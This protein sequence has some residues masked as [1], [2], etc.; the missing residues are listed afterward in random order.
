VKKD[1]NEAL[2]DILYTELIQSPKPTYVDEAAAEIAL[3]S[4][5]SKWIDILCRN[6]TALYLLRRFARCASRTRDQAERDEILGNFLLAFLQLVDR[7]E[8]TTAR[9]QVERVRL[10]YQHLLTA[11]KNL[12]LEP[13]YPLNHWN[14]LPEDLRPLSFALRTQ[15]FGLLKIHPDRTLKL[16]FHANEMHD[17]LWELACQDTL[18]HRLHFLLAA[19][20]GVLQEEQN[21][22]ITSGFILSLRLAKGKSSI[23]TSG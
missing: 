21:V 5:K 3:A 19:C 2:T 12:L 13:G 14:N 18:P 15:I 1:T 4:S 8:E 6:E 11:L 7:F 20:R 9:M 10:D 16:D 17:Q 22:K 23:G